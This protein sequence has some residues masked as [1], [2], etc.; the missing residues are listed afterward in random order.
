MKALSVCFIF[1]EVPL[2]RLCSK[3]ICVL[4]RNYRL[5]LRLPIPVCVTA[6]SHHS[7]L[8]CALTGVH[9]TKTQKTKFEIIVF[10][11]VLMLYRLYSQGIDGSVLCVCVCVLRGACVRVRLLR[12]SGMGE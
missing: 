2:P 10:I 12:S 7:S 3:I 6:S 9:K 5:F 11:I 8:C 1:S 4:L